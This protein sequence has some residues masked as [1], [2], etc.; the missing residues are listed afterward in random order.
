MPYGLKNDTNNLVVRLR[1][2]TVQVQETDGT[3]DDVN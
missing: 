3:P 1:F 2:Q